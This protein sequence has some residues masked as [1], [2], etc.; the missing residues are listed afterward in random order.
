MDSSFLHRRG[1]KIITGGRE[2]YALQSEREGVG[3][4]GA[5]SGVKSDR[6]TYRG[7]ENY[8]NVCSNAEWGTR[9]ATRKL[10]F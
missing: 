5:G 3:K 7:S 6:E 4:R 1:N 9:V 10:R 8:K 2:R